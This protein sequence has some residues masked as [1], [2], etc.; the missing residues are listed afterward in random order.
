MQ[1]AEEKLPLDI[2]KKEA[3]IFAKALEREVMLFSEKN[4]IV[5]LPREAVIAGANDYSQ[6]I[7]ER[8][9][10]QREKK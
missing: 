3:E 5:L 8:I 4:H 9:M 1:K 2:I 7:R 10:Q 6:V